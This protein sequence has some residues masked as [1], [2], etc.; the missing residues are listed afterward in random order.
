MSSE[1]LVDTMKDASADNWVDSPGFK[2][3]SAQ[4]ELIMNNNIRE[5]NHINEKIDSIS[6]ESKKGDEEICKRLDDMNKRAQE[7]DVRLAVVETKVD[8]ISSSTKWI[9]RT[10]VG[11]IVLSIVYG[12][13]NEIGLIQKF[14]GLFN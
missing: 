13:L 7:S 1:R 3:L 11:G 2:V 6:N 8:G 12:A 5:H 14:I 9:L 10:V 4:Q